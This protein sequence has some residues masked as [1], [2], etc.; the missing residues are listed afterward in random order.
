MRRGGA[1][2]IHYA[3]IPGETV[4]LLNRTQA[5]DEMLMSIVTRRAGKDCA[6]GDWLFWVVL[7]LIALAL[8]CTVN[9]F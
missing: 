5:P 3:L 9:G 8:C 7:A 4:K 1:H 2:A 6:G